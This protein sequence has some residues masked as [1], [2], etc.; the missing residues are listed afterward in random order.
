MYLRATKSS[1]INIFVTNYPI[2]NQNSQKILM[3]NINK[4]MK[5]YFIDYP[6]Y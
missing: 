4:I 3:H 1:N 5:Y 2:L 6:V